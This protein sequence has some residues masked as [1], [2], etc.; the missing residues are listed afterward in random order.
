MPDPGKTRQQFKSRTELFIGPKHH[1]L[2]G[3]IYDARSAAEHLNENQYLENFNRAVRLDLLRKV[4]IVDHI[5]RSSLARIVGSPALWPHF[6]NTTALK[7]FWAL[8]ADDRQRIWGEPIDP[9]EAV[10]EFDPE[11]I[12]DGLLGGP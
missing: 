3:E 8:S 7:R 9:L 6:A 10:A 5:A 11:R 2:M 4:V 12:H 1:D